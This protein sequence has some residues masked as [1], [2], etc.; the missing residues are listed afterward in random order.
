MRVGTKS[1]LFGVH[2]FALH[3][4]FVAIAWRKLYGFPYDPRLWCAFIVHDWGYWG[5]PNMDGPEGEEHPFLGA[6][7][8]SA[9]FDRGRATLMPS[10]WYQFTLYHSRFL[11][12]SHGKPFSKL[13]VADKLA[14]LQYPEW[15]YLRLA[16]ASGEIDEYMANALAG[17]EKN[18]KFAAACAEFLK[19]GDKHDWLKAVRSYMQ[20]WVDAHRYKTQDD[21]THVRHG[22]DNA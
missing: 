20:A 4:I 3:P 9:L 8:M 15:L 5:M 22:D 13:A 2:Q 6:L 10:S 21:W 19:T 14:I 16:S 17:A 18:P 11:A 7:I 1:L 12:K